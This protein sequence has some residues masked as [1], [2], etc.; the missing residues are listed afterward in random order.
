MSG[1]SDSDLHAESPW[2]LDVESPWVL[3]EDG[4]QLLTTSRLTEGSGL[5]MAGQSKSTCSSVSSFTSFAMASIS[6]ELGA[7]ATSELTS[8]GLPK[9]A[10]KSSRAASAPCSPNVR[11]LPAPCL[12]SARPL[13][14][15]CA[16][17][18]TSGVVRLRRSEGDTHR[19]TFENCIVHLRKEQE[20][21]MAEMRSTAAK[22][23]AAIAEC[24]RE[25]ES[26]RQQIMIQA[27][28]A[29]EAA[30]TARESVQN[31]S[32]VP[33]HVASLHEM[34]EGLCNSAHG[35]VQEV[36]HAPSS[37]PV[38]A[39]AA[40]EVHGLRHGGL[41]ESACAAQDEFRGEMRQV[42]MKVQAMQQDLLGN[43]AQS[44]V[45]TDRKEQCFAPKIAEKGLSIEENV[46]TESCEDIA[47]LPCIS[48]QWQHH[49]PR[50]VAAS[51]NAAASLAQQEHDEP[52]LWHSSDMMSSSIS[53]LA[54]DFEARF[55]KAAELAAA[56]RAEVADLRTL[57]EDAFRALANELAE[58]RAD[59]CAAVDQA[60]SHS[61]EV[62]VKT[63]SLID[64][65]TE[66]RWNG[67]IVGHERS[68]QNQEAPAQSPSR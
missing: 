62:A 44:A 18:E 68:P 56:D 21:G 35:V 25:L 66:A 36:T 4:S 27:D 37:L 22:L 55:R 50:V 43:L 17:S 63:A 3:T 1:F 53:R 67:L 31:A 39:A 30:R 57:L 64:E 51:A 59:H 34:R 32:R 26:Q 5:I 42:R 6:S 8:N 61:N 33:S 15:R 49:P 14:A 52:S 48:S 58:E 10:K 19:F 11:P 16:L 46:I 60:V 13:R 45:L 41:S 54:N 2:I 12:P 65:I 9:L 20:A 7:N 24:R 28:A 29:L 23:E 47:E 38:L 40:A